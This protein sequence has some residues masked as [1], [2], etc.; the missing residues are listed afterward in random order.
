MKIS[1]YLK[2]RS[3]YTRRSRSRA[4]TCYSRLI[5]SIVLSICGIDS[6]LSLLTQMQRFRTVGFGASCRHFVPF[7]F[8]TTTFLSGKYIQKVKIY[9]W[10][11][12]F[13]KIV[14]IDRLT[15]TCYHRSGSSS[16]NAQSRFRIP[17]RWLR[18]RRSAQSAAY[19]HAIVHFARQ[20]GILP[21]K[22]LTSLQS[23][24]RLGVWQTQ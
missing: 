10:N 13:W 5:I 3:S 7:V 21:L 2:F 16:T 23:S 12:I 8:F 18:R 6:S 11:F 15:K 24:G 4:N 20:S 17:S 14:K 9:Q 1:R 22:R 19:A